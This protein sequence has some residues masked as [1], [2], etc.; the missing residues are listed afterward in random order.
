MALVELL[1][2][3]LNDFYTKPMNKTF[4]AQELICYGFQYLLYLKSY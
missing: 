1:V 3:T 2:F 4:Y